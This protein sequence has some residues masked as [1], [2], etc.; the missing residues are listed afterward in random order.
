MYRKYHFCSFHGRRPGRTLYGWLYE[1]HVTCQI[2]LKIE[3]NCIAIAAS[4]NHRYPIYRW[5][6]TSDAGQCIRWTAISLVCLCTQ[7][8]YVIWPVISTRSCRL[9]ACVAC[10]K[11]EKER[12]SP[13]CICNLCISNVINVMKYLWIHS[14]TGQRGQLLCSA[15]CR[16]PYARG[17]SVQC[18][19]P[20]HIQF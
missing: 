2:K 20:N 16:N 9:T 19:A 7:F 6:A 11:R 17:H 10:G 8:A 12:C 15:I 5:Q 18:P 4:G 3:S 13:Q 1:C 14:F